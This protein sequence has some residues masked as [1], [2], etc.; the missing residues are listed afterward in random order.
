MS[1]VNVNL[2]SHSVKL[3]SRLPTRPTAGQRTM[4]ISL[5]MGL[6]MP[7]HAVVNTLSEESHC[8][9]QA[10]NSRGGLRGRHGGASCS[11]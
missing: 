2:S 3:P 5:R 11:R 7:S 8:R 10:R 9:T 4:A 6:D 1:W